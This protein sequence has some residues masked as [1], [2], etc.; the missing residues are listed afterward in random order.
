MFFVCLRTGR[1]ANSEAAITHLDMFAAR[2]G[3]RLV[4]CTERHRLVVYGNPTPELR[5]KLRAM[6]PAGGSSDSQNATQEIVEGG[7]YSSL[8]GGFSRL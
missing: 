8:I 1:Y 4:Q 5:A 2:F 6:L 7:T 3:D